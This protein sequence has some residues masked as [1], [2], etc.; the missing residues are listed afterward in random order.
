MHRDLKLISNFVIIRVRMLIEGYLMLYPKSIF[1]KRFLL[2]LIGTIA[3]SALCYFFVDK[4]IAFWFS[5]HHPF[6]EELLLLITYI[7]KVFDVVSA[8]GVFVVHMFSWMIGRV[9]NFLRNLTLTSITLVITDFW[10]E[11]M[12]FMFGRYWPQTWTVDHN[13]SLIDTDDYGFH[14][15]AS[16]T[17]AFQA[18]PSAHTSLTIASVTFLALRY[19]FLRMPAMLICI[20]VPLS[21]VALNYHFLGD[22]IAGAGLGYMVAYSID[23][24][25]KDR[26][27]DLSAPL[28][29]KS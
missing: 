24:F 7:P 15:F 6:P 20:S 19:P 3:I 16:K 21:L 2:V 22:T 13:P 28:S 23:T 14:F 11:W 8:L 26:A 25:N 29:S 27:F 5:K 1:L 18:F 4:P 17:E 10:T 12:K 9:S